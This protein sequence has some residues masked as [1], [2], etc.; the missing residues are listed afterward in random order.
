MFTGIVKS[1]GRID[2]WSSTSTG[3]RLAVALPAPIA[4]L[5][6][7]ESIAVNGVCLTVE[8]DARPERLTFY[9]SDETINRSTFAQLKPGDAV[10]LERALRAD[11][12]L[13]G[14][15]VSGHVD[16]IGKIH[17]WEMQG[18]AWT[19][20]VDFPEALA[21][22]IAVKGSICIDGISLTVATLA[23]NR[24]GVAVIPHTAAQTTL[25]DATAGRAVNLE[26][27]MLARYVVHALNL[28]G[29]AT[30]KLNEQ[31]FKNAGF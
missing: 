2:A 12:R 17:R 24:F 7:G 4:D 25:K 14:H 29:G 1:L 27:D 20:E 16:G 18:E 31:F 28:R 10:N 13:G 30:G 19:L 21:P 22:F 9:L 23:G 8:D 11:E 15:L 26:I 6:I 5:E 3:R